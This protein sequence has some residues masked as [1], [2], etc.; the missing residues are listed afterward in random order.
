MRNIDEENSSGNFEEN[1]AANIESVSVADKPKYT[2]GQN[3]KIAGK[4]AQS[5]KKHVM[6]A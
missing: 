1:V 5:K 3:V 4:G 6:G 2:D